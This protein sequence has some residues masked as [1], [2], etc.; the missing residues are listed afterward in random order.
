MLKIVL[1]FDGAIAP[2]NPGG[3]ASYG[4]H[5]SV[6]D[7]EFTTGN[8][9]IGTGPEMS[10]NYAE[11]FAVYKGLEQVNKIVDDNKGEKFLIFI[12]GDSQIVINILKKK[13]QKTSRD[14][15]YYP[16]YVLAT[17]ELS[18]LRGKDIA[19]FI[20]WVSREDNQY[21]DDLSKKTR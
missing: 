2:I 18:K 20:D 13:R 7:K 5:I 19:V 10:N 3:T 14:G 21:A 12:K 11:F 15:L 17:K 4:F 1:H 9:I 8:G 16:A 6:D